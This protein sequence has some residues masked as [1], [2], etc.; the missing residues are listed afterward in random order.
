MPKSVLNVRVYCTVRKF[1][2]LCTA[3]ARKYFRKCKET[4]PH[5]LQLIT[6]ES[7]YMS[8]I[9]YM[10]TWELWIAVCIYF[11]QKTFFSHRN[12]VQSVANGD[13]RHTE[14]GLYH[15]DIRRSWSP[16]RWNLTWFFHH[17]LLPA[18]RK[19]SYSLYLSKTMA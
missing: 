19:F 12:D 6:L 11:I 3:D 17:S 18:K 15:R 7:M 1:V 10:N 16:N 8:Y 9:D 13:R 4:I 5:L 14:I 2:F